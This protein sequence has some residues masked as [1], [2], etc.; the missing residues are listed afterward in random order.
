MRLQTEEQVKHHFGS[1]FLAYMH[2]KSRMRD[3][4]SLKSEERV[5]FLLKSTYN[6]QSKENCPFLSATS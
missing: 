4:F 3:K 5:D 2:F 6:C 1:F